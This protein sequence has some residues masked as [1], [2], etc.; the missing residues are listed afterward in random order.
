MKPSFRF[1]HHP[2]DFFRNADVQS[3]PNP[4]DDLESFLIN[5]LHNYQ[6]DDRIA[7]LDDLYKLCFNEFETEEQQS[8]FMLKN[9]IP[10]LE[11]AKAEISALENHLKQEAYANFYNLTL[12]KQIEVING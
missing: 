12:N 3:M 4:E 2:G 7:Y 8:D 1:Y 10:D 5:F 11:G 9:N 6:S